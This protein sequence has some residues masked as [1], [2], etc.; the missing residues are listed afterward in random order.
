MGVLIWA[1]LVMGN[2]DPAKMRAAKSAKEQE[3]SRR[4]E[5]FEQA[6]EMEHHQGGKRSTRVGQQDCLMENM[7]MV[8]KRYQDS[9]LVNR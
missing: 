3:A 8:P 4:K 5:Q 2:F 9:V 6:R 1:F 7:E